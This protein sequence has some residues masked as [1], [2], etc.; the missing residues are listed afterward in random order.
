M[1]TP[2]KLTL[3]RVLLIP[4]F[5]ILFYMDYP[6]CALITFVIA[7]L[8]DTFD[9]Y[10]ARRNN[11]I[12]TFGKLMDPLA[13]KLLV[14]AVLV[15]FVDK[16]YIWAWASIIIISREFIVTG[17]RLL[18][19]GESEILSASGWGKAKTVSQLV[20]IIAILTANMPWLDGYIS[21]IILDVTV[22]IT[23]VLTIYSGFDYIRKNR[24]L[25]KLR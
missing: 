16:G 23:V 21:P 1:N 17:V 3:L 5:V 12:T 25:I 13:D 18:A 15:C 10:L 7:S 19:I 11:Q 22:I 9:G 2:N 24:H 4:V 8:T 20:A 14:T 6:I